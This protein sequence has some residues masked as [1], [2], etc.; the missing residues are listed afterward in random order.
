MG[1]AFSDDRS[2]LPFLAVFEGLMIL[3]AIL[4]HEFR[5]NYFVFFWLDPIVLCHGL[6]E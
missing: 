6:R 4:I 2:G 3:S 5:D 1:G